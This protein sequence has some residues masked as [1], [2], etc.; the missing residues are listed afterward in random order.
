MTPDGLPV[1]EYIA[2]EG[3][4]MLGVSLALTIGVIIPTKHIFTFPLMGGQNN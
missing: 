3:H 1:L 4:S 2:K